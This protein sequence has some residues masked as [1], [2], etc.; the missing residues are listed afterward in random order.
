[1]IHIR[2]TL[3]NFLESQANSLSK[4]PQPVDSKSIKLYVPPDASLLKIECTGGG[5]V[6][7][8]TMDFEE[9]EKEQ[10]YYN[11]CLIRSSDLSE[12]LTAIGSN[13]YVTEVSGLQ[14]VIIKIEDKPETY[15]YAFI[16]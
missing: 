2:E 9:E 6:L 1:M 8:G 3:K 10:N 5:F 16:V 13:I 4:N 7:S 15:T 11:L 12:Q 14:N